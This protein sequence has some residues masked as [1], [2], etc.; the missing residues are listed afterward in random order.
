M[1]D[2]IGPAISRPLRLRCSHIWRDEVMD[3][4]M[5]PLGASVTVGQDPGCTFIVPPARSKKTKL[6]PTFAILRPGARGYVLTLG[7]GMGGRVC[8][9]GAEMEVAEFL[10]SGGSGAEGA[11]GNFRATPVAAG[12]WGVIHLD[13]TGDQSFF[14][15]FTEEAPALP[16]PLWLLGPLL[17]PLAFSLV[18]HGILLTMTFLL[19]DDRNSFLFPGSRELMTAYLIERPPD[20]PPPQEEKDQTAAGVETA[21]EKLAEPAATKDKKGKAG[22]EGT[23]RSAARDPAGGDPAVP[24]VGLLRH[25]KTLDE[26]KKMGGMEDAIGK[27]IARLKRDNPIFGDS[28]AGK[29]SGTGFGNDKD[30]T[31]TTRG[32]EKGGSGGGGKS[33]HDVVTQKDMDT[34][35]ERPGKGSGG[36]KPKEVRLERGNAEGDFTGLS[37][38]E[39]DRVIKSRA[40]SIRACYQNEVNRKPGLAGTVVV[41]FTIK[42]RAGRGEVTR[43][44]VVGGKSTLNN[45]AVEDCVLRKIQSLTFPA[46]GGAFVNYPFIFSQG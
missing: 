28:G 16:P 35:G 9:G 3:D 37:K 6:P 33:S 34:G 29:G 25:T 1:S 5:V 13:A 10:R 36:T 8:V 24:Q 19:R 26:I 39:V 14:F 46:K 11:E 41:R 42:D 44:T 15:Q 20:D 12:D 17:A 23:Q 21:P 27:S 32:A 43:A 38:E 7:A 22:G 30:G 31:G 18:L 2:A 40:G 45:R 4:A